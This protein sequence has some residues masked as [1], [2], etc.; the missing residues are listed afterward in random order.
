MKFLK[1]SSR[2]ILSL[3]PVGD[4]LEVSYYL[5]QD[6][7]QGLLILFRCRSTVG[8]RASAPALLLEARIDQNPVYK[9]SNPHKQAADSP[10]GRLKNFQVSTN[11]DQKEEVFR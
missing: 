7:Y 4:P 2:G 5:H 11:F 1:S 6:A 10:S 9:V 8:P 3:D